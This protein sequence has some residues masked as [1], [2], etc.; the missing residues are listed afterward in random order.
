[1]TEH[2]EGSYPPTK[3]RK[4]LPRIMDRKMLTLVICCPIRTSI[5][6]GVSFCSLFGKAVRTPVGIM[7]KVSAFFYSIC[8]AGIHSKQTEGWT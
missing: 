2:L 7:A 5:I 6:Q 4:N 1:M 3:I 8:S